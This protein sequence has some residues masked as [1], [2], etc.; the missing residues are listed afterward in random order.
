MFSQAYQKIKHHPNPG[1][2]IKTGIAITAVWIDN[3]NRLGQII[4][5]YVVIGYDD[6]NS[7]IH[8]RIYGIVT[9]GP[10]VCSNNEIYLVCQCDI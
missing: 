5:R 2:V 6:V 9:G 1:K 3:G 7:L 10:A 4:C 8:G